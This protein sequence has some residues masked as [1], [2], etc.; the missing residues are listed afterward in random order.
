MH[1]GNIII[2]DGV[3]N[4][5]KTTLCKTLTK[6]ENNVLIEEVPL[7]IKNHKELFMGK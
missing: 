7:F 3:S 4:S 1:L 2:I 6:D 5:G